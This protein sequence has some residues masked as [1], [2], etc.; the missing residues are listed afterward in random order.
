MKKFNCVLLVDDDEDACFLN[1]LALTG[2]DF[3]SHTHI[4]ND[5]NN[6]LKFVYDHCEDE[7][8]EKELCPDIIFLDISMPVMDGFGFLEKFREIN[9]KTKS[10]Y[11]NIFKS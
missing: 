11:F 2:V 10:F 1:N 7:K 5:G 9:F 3:A 4:L 6:A 8:K